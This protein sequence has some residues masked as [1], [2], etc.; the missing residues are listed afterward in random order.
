MSFMRP[1]QQL[2]RERTSARRGLAEQ[3]LSR[4]AEA[5][6]RAPKEKPASSRLNC[7]LPD[8][9]ARVKRLI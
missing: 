1:R 7:P 4:E 6:G 8:M 2:W 3:L 5:C 9:D